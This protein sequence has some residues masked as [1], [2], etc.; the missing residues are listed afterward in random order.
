MA[1]VSENI[2][3][4]G[5]NFLL[6]YNFENLYSLLSLLGHFT[7]DTALSELEKKKIEVWCIGTN[8][9]GGS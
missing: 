3:T 5:L 9:R 7:I 8:G 6:G 1:S 2:G 4:K